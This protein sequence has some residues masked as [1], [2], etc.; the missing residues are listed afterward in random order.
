LRIHKQRARN[1]R[2]SAVA[3]NMS[4]RMKHL[5]TPRPASKF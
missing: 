4:C 3:A 2:N 1:E 5:G